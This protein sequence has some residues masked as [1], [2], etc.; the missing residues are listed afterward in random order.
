MSYSLDLPADIIA[1]MRTAARDADVSAA[2][3]FGFGGPNWQVERPSGI[4]IGERTLTSADNVMGLAFLP[5]PSPVVADIAAAR[6]LSDDWQFLLLDGLL[7]AGD[8]ITSVAD[9]RY[10]FVVQSLEPWYDD[11]KAI[12]KPRNS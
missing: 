5:K 12:L 7:K 8:V 10:V 9:S 11:T 6:V 4:G 3:A 1:Q 2:R